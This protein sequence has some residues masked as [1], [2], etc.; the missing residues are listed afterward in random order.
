MRVALG[1][2]YDGS[3][4]RGWQRQKHDTE[5]VQAHLEAAL[6]FVAD[7]E[8]SV[9]CAGRTDTGVHGVGQVV[10]FDTQ[11]LRDEKAWVFGGNARLP[12]TIAIKWARRVDEEFH[13]RFS[14]TARAYRYAIYN[15][16]VR[17]A[18]GMSHLTWN[19]RPLNLEAMQQAAGCLVGE[20]DFSSFRAVGCQ[21]KSPVRAV[22]S[23]DLYRRDRLIVMDIRANAFLQHM[24]R[25]I[26]GTLMAVGSGKMPVGWVREV[27]EHRDRTKG[28]VTAP[29][30][31]LYF[32]KV[33]YP[34]HFGI[35]AP[36]QNVPF[37]PL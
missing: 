36:E 2:E 23:L 25:N 17:P 3:P 18:I 32:M 21:S 30:Y 34:D 12:D 16:P 33:D 13:A 35:P 9:V 37:M 7:H 28:G 8:V 22:L 19:F 31:G 5:T 6:G 20:H 10:H 14:A 4:F 27:L 26:A 15:H 29:P 11:A 1:I 24:V